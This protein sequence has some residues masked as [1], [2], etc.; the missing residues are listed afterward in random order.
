[1]VI[2]HQ[3]MQ[4]YHMQESTPYIAI[5][6][7]GALGVSS[8]WQQVNEVDPHTQQLTGRVYFHNTVTDETSWDPPEG[9]APIPAPPPASNTPTLPTG[10]EEHMDSSSGRPYW[11]NTAAN[12]TTWDR[13]TPQPVP[14]PL[15]ELPIPVPAPQIQ[16]TVQPPPPPATEGALQPPSDAD[17]I[18]KRA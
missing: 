15:P 12:E 8:P 16:P 17:S 18:S 11:H 14:P 10:W 2:V 6:S 5:N 9:F 1:V 7:I 3:E 4:L 13:P